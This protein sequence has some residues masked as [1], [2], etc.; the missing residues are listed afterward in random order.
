MAALVAMPLTA[1]DE[2]SDPVVDPVIIG[3]VTGTV[4][5][6]GEGL[7]GV[8]VSLVGPVDQSAATGAGGTFTFTNVPEG[9][10]GVSID[11]SSQPDVSWGQTARTTTITVNGET[12]TVDFPG[13]Y[14]KTSAITGVVSASGAPLAGVAV[15]VT[16][17][18]D[19]FSG[20]YVTD[21]A[22]MY[23]ASGLRGGT[24]TVAITAPAGVTFAATSVD[25]TVGTGQTQTASFPGEAVQLGMIT[26]AVTID[27]V[28][29]AGIAVALSGDTTGATET[30]PGGAY[31]FNNLV[32]GSYTVTITPCGSRFRR[33]VE[34]PP[35]GG[36]GRKRGCELRWGRPG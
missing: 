11:P 19:T 12:Q 30:G 15:S 1:C 32:P 25:V 18:P 8:A 4:S 3:T 22:G 9:S 7:S 6:D 10:Y 34:G 24:Y 16:G 21:A 28:G 26:G 23:V 14:I 31:A 35:H 33:R 29:T 27:N 13:S 5:A 36:S 20:S 2:D 17:G